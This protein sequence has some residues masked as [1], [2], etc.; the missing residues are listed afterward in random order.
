MQLPN[1]RE[2]WTTSPKAYVKNSLIVIERLLSKDG[3]RY[4]LKL[5]VKNPFPTSCK[6][7]IDIME[8]LDQALASR[9]MQ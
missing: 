9:Y 4:V 5:N 8:E 7:E 3:D 2:V 1:G 6:P